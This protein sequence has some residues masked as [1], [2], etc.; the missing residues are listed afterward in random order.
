MIRIRHVF[1]IIIVIIHCYSEENVWHLCRLVKEQYPGIL[2]ECYAVF[3]SNAQQSIPLWNQK[4]GQ[5]RHGFV[6]W[7]TFFTQL[8]LLPP[9]FE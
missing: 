4:A 5:N 7:V 9:L 6:V 2:G 1:L 3:I 8:C